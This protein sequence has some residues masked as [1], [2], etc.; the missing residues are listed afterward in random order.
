MNFFTELSEI[1]IVAVQ[2]KKRHIF[3]MRL[4][5]NRN[6][7]HISTVPPA[8]SIAAFAFSLT[9]LTLKVSLAFSSP[10]PRILTLSVL[11][12]QVR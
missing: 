4:A 8:A 3:T 7:L 12:N 2:T 10:L 11:A 5:N 6:Y 1:L 9:A